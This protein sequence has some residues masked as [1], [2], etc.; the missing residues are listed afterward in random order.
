[1]A[2]KRDYYEVLGV[3]KDATAD[4]IKSAYRKL[5]MKYHPDRNPD[6]PEAKEK[7][8]EISE[9][10]EV[11]SNPEKR[12]AY[13]QFGHQGVN[14]GPGGFN[15]GRDFSHFQ[16]VDLNDILNSFL[17]GMGGGFSGFSGWGGSRQRRVDPNAPRR[18]DDMTFRL[19]VEFDE[20]VFGSERTIDLQLPTECDE[21][22]GT[23]SSD[24][25]RTTCKTCRGSGVE[26]GG[27]GFFQIRQTCHTCGG[28]GSVIEKPCRKCHGTGR[29]AKAQHISLK[30]PA[31]VDTGSRLRLAGKGAGGVRGGEP[32]DL[33]VL[34][35]VGESDIFE[36][37]GLNL[38]VD[39]PVSPVDAALGCTVDVP[40]PD[41]TAEIKLPEGTPNG[42]VMRLRG[43]GM[44]GLRGSMRG[45]LIARI[46]FEVPVNLDKK[47]KA[48]LETF[49]KHAQSGNFPEKDRFKQR[50]TVFFKHKEK[51]QKK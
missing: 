51:L 27:S 46:V 32:G 21:C 49:Q 10:Y 43:Q 37:D 28:E 39:I 47:A 33:Y 4:Q 31:G 22:H 50:T 24:G 3:A 38:Y 34:L 45:D 44:A 6:N 25:K 48:A 14:F 41:G 17:N 40:T 23:G 30:I 7:F 36:R 1:M 29:V 19:D 26:V 35:Q 42:K 15:F 18:G 5:A 8:T 2:D 16:D 12:Q 13:D 9:A 20:A 11:L